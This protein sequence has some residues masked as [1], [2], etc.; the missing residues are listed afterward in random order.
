MQ[1]VY[2]LEYQDHV[3]MARKSL[4]V[5][6]AVRLVGERLESSPTVKV[7]HIR[8]CYSD[9]LNCV[10]INLKLDLDMPKEWEEERGSTLPQL[11][12]LLGV[13]NLLLN[14]EIE[15]RPGITLEFN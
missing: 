6:E 7:R 11:A 4:I 13:E 10:K 8:A 1:Q 15:W 14:L 3:N 9:L 5:A 12:K 2:L